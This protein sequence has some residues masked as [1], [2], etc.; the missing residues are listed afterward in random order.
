MPGSFIGM[1]ERILIL[2]MLMINEYPSIGLIIT[3]K[4]VVRYK[5]IS[6]YPVFS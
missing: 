5:K 6:E 4:S 3:V 2:L 1:L